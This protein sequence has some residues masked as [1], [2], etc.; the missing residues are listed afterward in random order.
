[1]ATTD[2]RLVMFTDAEADPD[3][4]D[5]G[6]SATHAL[7]FTGAAIDVATTAMSHTKQLHGGDSFFDHIVYLGCSP[8][9]NFA[10]DM[11]NDA[12]ADSSYISLKQARAFLYGDNTMVPRCSA[13]ATPVND[14]RSSIS[15]A[16]SQCFFSCSACGSETSVADINWRKRAAYGNI[17]LFVHG[18]FPH[19]AVPGEQLMLAL[20]SA[21]GSDWKY[22]YLQNPVLVTVNGT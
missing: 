2:N 5:K 13:C 18:V 9:V 8:V 3:L 22:A 11:E 15:A 12:I 7:G 4:S 16:G 20:A 6:I 21:S 1:M 14:W 10:A 17:F 19:E